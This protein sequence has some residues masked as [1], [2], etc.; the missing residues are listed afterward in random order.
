MD[1]DN[2][3]TM[4]EE[5]YGPALAARRNV[6]FMTRQDERGLFIYDGFTGNEGAA[7]KERRRQC[8]ELRNV[9]TQQLEANSSAHM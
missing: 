3:I 5:V 4:W 2:T 6:L 9:A 1:T 8:E 7:A